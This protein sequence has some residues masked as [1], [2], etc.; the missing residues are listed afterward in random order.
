MNR[1]EYFHIYI[2][3]YNQILNPHTICYGGGHGG[4]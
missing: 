2:S 3:L 1:P 4:I